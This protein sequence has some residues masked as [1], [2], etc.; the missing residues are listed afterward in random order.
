MNVDDIWRRE[1]QLRSIYVAK[2]K[3]SSNAPMK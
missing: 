3:D 1:P 2:S